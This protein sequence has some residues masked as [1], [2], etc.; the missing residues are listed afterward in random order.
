[1]EAGEFDNPV[2][3]DARWGFAM[4]LMR[5]FISSDPDWSYVGYDVSH[6]AEETVALAETVNTND[7]DPS[8]F[9]DHGDKLT[10]D[11][12]WMGGSLTPHGTIDYYERGVA[13]D[14]KARDGVRLF[15]RPAVAYCVGGTGPDSTNH[16][17][18]LESWLDSGDGTGA[19]GRPVCHSSTGPAAFWQRWADCLR[20]SRRG[21]L[22][23]FRRPVR[24]QEFQL[25]QAGLA[26]SVEFSQAI[27]RAAYNT[28][29]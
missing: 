27:V 22:R 5:F 24:S 19:T 29:V 12:G 26:A 15:V 14:P 1:M 28:L 11:N 21:H 4:G 6:F 23:R 3:P 7:P 20:P 16:I 18:A 8:A 25:Q 9:R 10:I 2:A 17:V 13:F